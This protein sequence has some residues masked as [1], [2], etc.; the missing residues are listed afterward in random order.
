MVLTMHTARDATIDEATLVY[1]S[2]ERA[3]IGEFCDKLCFVAETHWGPNWHRDFMAKPENAFLAGWENP[4]DPF[5]LLKAI[6]KDQYSTLIMI[7]CADRIIAQHASDIFHTRILWAHRAHNQQMSSIKYNV[8][9]LARFAKLAHLESHR[10][11]QSAH[12]CLMHMVNTRGAPWRRPR[13]N[14]LPPRS[15]TH[16]MLPRGLRRPLIGGLWEE[17]LPTHELLLLTKEKELVDAK[18]RVSQ[19]NRWPTKEL[20][21]EAIARWISLGPSTI[22]LFSDDRDGAT[23][24]FLEGHPYMLGYVGKEP[25][26]LPREHRGFIG[27]I[28]YTFRRNKLIDETTGRRMPAITPS[29]TRICELLTARGFAPGDVFRL[30]SYGDMVHISD[31]GPV[32]ILTLGQQLE[33]Q[34]LGIMGPTDRASGGAIGENRGRKSRS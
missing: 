32:R 19:K 22:K 26:T 18:T 15:T 23:V 31:N 12:N 10:D 8:L 4:R 7:L 29:M 13:I 25:Y 3:V 2:V 11:A 1:L 33:K 6:A 24:A 34:V 28:N 16:A 30:T 9:A 21:D 14:A 20:A 17:D 27:Y 5:Y